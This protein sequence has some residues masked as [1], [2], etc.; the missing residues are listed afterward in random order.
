MSKID[1]LIEQ[2]EYL[3]FSDET[4]VFKKGMFPSQRFHGFLPYLREDNNI[5]FP[6]LIA[7]LL[8]KNL[9]QLEQEQCE[10][11][12]KIIN[13]IR[14][15]YQTY[16]SLSSD[17]L[18]NFYQTKPHQQYP[19][20]L[21]LSKF[22]HFILADDADDTV[23]I[24]MTLNNLSSE[25][26][27]RIREKLVQFSNLNPK[28]IKG[29]DSQYS[30]LPFYAIW[31]GSG[32]MPIELDICVLCNILYFTFINKLELNLQDKASLEL[33]K[34]AIDNND[35]VTNRFQISGVYYA[36]TSIILYHIT[37]LCSV[38]SEPSMYFNT[39]RLVEILRSQ[40]KTK[41]I[42]E[43][44]ILSI[45]LMNLGQSPEP[46]AWELEDKSFKKDFKAFPFFIA[47]IL[48]GS[49]NKILTQFKKYKLFHILFRCDAFYY[50]LF[51]E[52]E[53][54]IKTTS[55][56]EILRQRGATNK[57]SS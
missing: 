50:A 15:N 5:F 3:Q 23:I 54:M 48:S 38:I 28:K 42:V 47:P 18:Y 13:G 31:F 24:S 25:R 26:I 57:S 49:S 17:S 45:S 29:I 35:I 44:I 32:R 9:K 14:K 40:L 41:S 1:A 30:E 11:V 2:L 36:K 21:V 55:N 20:G 43:K 51:L 16:S 56:S 27:N 8:L 53:I 34:R 52:Y 7:F 19:N 4:G 39:E 12:N 22:K 33:I 6:A 37:R 10:K 46:I